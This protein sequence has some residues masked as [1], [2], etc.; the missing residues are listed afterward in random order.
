M[1]CAQHAKVS[2][3]CHLGGAR[4]IL[5]PM[6]RFVASL[7]FCS[8]LLGQIPSPAHAE[9][10]LIPTKLPIQGF[11]PHH[12]LDDADIFEVGGWDATQI[13]HFLVSKGSA[14]ATMQLPDIDGVEKRPAD[15][16]WRVAGSYKLNP[17]YLLVLIQKEQSLVEG[18]TPTQRQLDWAAGYAVCDSC[19]MSD[20][21][22]QAFKGFANQIEYAAKQHRERYLFQI[23]VK[24]ATIA[25]HAPGKTSLIDSVPVTP[26]NQATAM[27]YSYTPHLHGNQNLWKIWRRWFSRSLPDSTIVT[28]KESGSS[29][30][31]RDGARRPLSRAVLASLTTDLGKVVRVSA[32]D[33]AAYPEGDALKFSNFSLIEIPDGS[34]YLLTGAQ[35]R[36]IVSTNV[37]KLLGFQ[38]DEVIE[39]RAEDLVDYTDGPDITEVSRYPTGI[40]AKDKQGS[41][42]YVEA[43]T[44][45]KIP[46][47]IFLSLYF[48]GRPAKKLKPS[49]WSAYP[50]G[51]PYQLKDGELVR[52]TT[53]TAVYVIDHGARRP[54][55]SGEDF[56]SFGYQWKNVLVIPD[57]V[58]NDYR[59]GDAM[60]PAWQIQSVQLANDETINSDL[61]PSTATTTLSS[62]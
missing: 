39:A 48:K 32:S 56:L 28:E 2:V 41:Y 5:S 13:Q 57:A 55:K 54:F 25:G 33:L 14:L 37:F 62:L 24:G 36:L 38:E 58:L 52:G 26:V 16:L 43:G 45:H 4:A 59:M 46:H 50:I 53:S 15:I 18:R 21:S 35:K 22:I 1:A 31:I 61:S 10:I 47:K 17:K 3:R 9:T 40:L 12:I 27:L 6:K 42:W 29:F 60:E 44:R 30:L 23:L 20:P 19:S 8:L 49:E 51:D 11:N 34:R 7:V